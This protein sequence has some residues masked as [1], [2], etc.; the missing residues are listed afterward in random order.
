MQTR[1]IPKTSWGHYLEALGNHK[2]YQTVRVRLESDELGTQPLATESPLVGIS[3]E[4]K[5]SQADAIEITLGSL[6]KGDFT[7]LIQHP[8]HL[9]VEEDD[10]GEV[11]VIN[12]EDSM[13]VKTLIF[14]GP[15]EHSRA[16]V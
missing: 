14:F 2:A 7:H 11:Q 10:T 1:E 16:E 15:K 4:L 5:G 9:Y 6:G 12:I 3:V 8:A 13:R